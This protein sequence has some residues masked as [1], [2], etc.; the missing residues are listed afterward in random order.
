VSDPEVETQLMLL[1]SPLGSEP[2]VREREQAAAWLL[3]HPERAY[4]VLLASAADGVAGPATIELL[5][6]FGNADS[7]PVLAGL[8]DATE[9]TGRA[10]SQALAEHPAPAALEALLAGL[11]AGGD[12]AIRCADALAARGDAE[13]C[14]A[15]REAAGSVDAVARYHAIQAAAALRCL[16]TEELSDLADSDPDPDVRELATSLL[17]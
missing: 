14:P 6:R 8:L 17:G 7:V 4:P 13:A 15:L 2:A 5:G 9:P 16:R 12:A 11:R 1:E 3:A 10:A